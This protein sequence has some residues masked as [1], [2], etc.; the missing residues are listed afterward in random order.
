M[1][2]KDLPS[3]I[4]DPGTGIWPVAFKS[5]PLI[6]VVKGMGALLG[7]NDFEPGVLPGRLIEMT[8]NAYESVFHFGVFVTI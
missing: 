4:D 5:N 6:P 7:L 8:V 3:P 1:N 2:I